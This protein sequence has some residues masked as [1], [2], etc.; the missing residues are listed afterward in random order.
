[1]HA[2]ASNP[3][4]YGKPITLDTLG[5]LF[6]HHRNR[7]GGWTMTQGANEG[8]AGAGAGAGAGTGAGGGQAAGSGSDAGNGGGQAG[9][10]GQGP[11]SGS[12]TGSGGSGSSNDTGFPKDTP[13]A[14]MTDK[15]QA[16]Y[17]KHQAR[18][19]EERNRGLLGDRTPEQLKKDLEAFEK[20]QREQQTPAEQALNAARDEGKQ[21]GLTAAR[22]ESATTLF[23][24]HLEGA[25]IE[26]GDLEELVAGLNVDNFVT[27]TGVDT[28]KLTNF[29]KR[30][31]SGKDTSS[32][33]QTRRRDFG[34]GQRPSGDGQRQSA[35]KAEAERRF[36]KTNQ[37]SGQG[38][39]S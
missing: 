14:E 28:T 38:A 11:G 22:R 29:A 31:T 23:R 17:Y 25:G 19:H 37:G 4:A 2:A 18:R 13:V 10:G 6:A 20:F 26:G 35:G 12:Q 21:A 27:D 1:M 7:F 16:A 30:F 33:S 5:D 34:G 8:G 15:E 3:F 24:G 32:G 9:S 36:K 39:S